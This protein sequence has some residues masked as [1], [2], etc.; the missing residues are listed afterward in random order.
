MEYREMSIETD[1]PQVAALRI[2]VEKR[3]GH[4]VGSRADFTELAQRIEAE[5]HEH[6]A[7]NTLRRLWGAMEGYRT[8]Y[9]RTLDVLSKYAGLGY[10]TDFCA[11][12]RSESGR[13]S[14]IVRDG[15]SVRVEDLVPGDRLRMG[16]LPDRLCVVEFTGGRKFKA[17]A[18]EN[19]TMKP[20][21]TFE[22]SMV[23]RGYPLYVDNFT[24]DGEVAPRYVMG[25]G[26]GITLLEKI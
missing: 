19:S 23:L 9:R 11:W 18:T 14:D 13:E 24:H 1:L 5:T 2:A 12:L 4:P 21:D 15:F 3:F 6:V 20:G 7:E 8:V 22:C 17:V 26:N 25:T 10:W 16:W